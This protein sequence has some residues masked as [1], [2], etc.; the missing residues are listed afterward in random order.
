MGK[1]RRIGILGERDEL[2]IE[3]STRLRGV[4]YTAALLTAWL[5]VK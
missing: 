4:G 3:V 5:H 1:I 2:Y